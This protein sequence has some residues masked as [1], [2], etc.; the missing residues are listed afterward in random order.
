MEPIRIS[1]HLLRILDVLAEAGG[2]ISSNEIIGKTEFSRRT[3]NTHV[4]MLEQFGIV[5]CIKLFTGYKYRLIKPA[6]QEA[7]ELW[8]RINTAREAMGEVTA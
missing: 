5:E 8:A 7:K 1:P 2:W 3:V 6:T 4:M